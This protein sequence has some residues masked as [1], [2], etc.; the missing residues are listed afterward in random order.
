[1]KVWLNGTLHD[2]DTPCISANDRGF[3][4]GDGLFET[5]QARGGAVLRLDAHLARLRRGASLI[6]L[7]LPRVDYSKVFGEVLSANRVHDGALRLT[8]TRGPAPRGV[9]PPALST[10]TMVI[11]VAEMPAATPVRLVI[12][13][14]TRRNEF[15][16]LSGIK[17]L[18]YLDSILA[19]Q[20]AASR[21]V[22]DALMLNTQG[23]VAETSMANVFVLKDGTL[24]TPPLREGAL[25]GVMRAEILKQGAIEHTIV[26]GDLAKARE[27]FITTSLGIR[28]VDE[29]ETRPLGDF[30]VANQLRE[31]LG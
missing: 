27:I 14:T 11:S 24:M 19:R 16:P 29:V 20:E 17:S 13:Q 23:R 30:S 21:G 7:H 31:K 2:A 10:P 22:D 18:N 8:I 5:L 9:L 3:T 6:G 1:M 26:P 28:S 25:P 15:S 12:A 4:L